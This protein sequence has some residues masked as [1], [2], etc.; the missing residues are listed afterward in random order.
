VGEALEPV[1]DQ[2]VIATKF[3]WD[4]QDGKCLGLHPGNVVN[5]REVRKT[6]IFIRISGTYQLSAKLK[7]SFSVQ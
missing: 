7:L 4:I 5:I 1:R 2:V 3:G 6:L